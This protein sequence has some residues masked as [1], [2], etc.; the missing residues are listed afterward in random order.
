MGKTYVF[1]NPL[2]NNKRGMELAKTVK[3]I[4]T[5]DEFEF[6]NILN[7]E[8]LKSF[9]NETDENEKVIIAGGDGTL[10]Y[11]LNCYDEFEKNV[12][13]YPCG[14]GND[15]ARDIGYLNKLILLNEHI[16]KIPYCFIN[17]EK[18]KYI[19]GVGIGIDGYVCAK[20][21]EKRFD[22]EDASYIKIALKGIFSDYKRSNATVWVDDK[23]Y[24][25]NDVWFLCAMKGRYCGGGF[26]MTP[27]Q[28]R[29]SDKGEISLL[30]VHNAP[31]PKILL[32]F[33]L[34]FKGKHTILKKSV[35]I[36]TGNSIKAEFDT[37]S[38]MQLDGES[39]TDISKLEI[40]TD[41]KKKELII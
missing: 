3:D 35:S 29:M 18:R 12:Y 32:A 8:N 9:I 2:S 11:F 28:D 21:N 41:T 24:K 39:Y 20:V 10:N 34:V 38:Y 14:N 37:P 23:K 31:I 17:G 19:N 7:I 26:M 4:I 27:K 40:E 1:Y 16:N 15:F 13:F 25:F 36:L 5:D 30:V 6:L 33:L 22:K